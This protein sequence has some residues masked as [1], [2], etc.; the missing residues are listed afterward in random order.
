MSKKDED[1]GKQK[2][3]SVRTTA[4]GWLVFP[5][6]FVFL[7]QPPDWHF[8]QNY[9][10]N[11]LTSS[12]ADSACSPSTNIAFRPRLVSVGNNRSQ[13]LLTRVDSCVFTVFCGSV[14]TL[15]LVC[16]RCGYTTPSPEMDWET[17]KLWRQISNCSIPGSNFWN[18]FML[19]KNDGLRSKKGVFHEVLE[20]A[21]CC[22]STPAPHK[23]L[24][25]QTRARC[26][27]LFPHLLKVTYHWLLWVGTTV[28]PSW[29][30]MGSL[31]QTEVV[32][33]ISILNLCASDEK[34]TAA[35]FDKNMDK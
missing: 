22:A 8:H 14:D 20:S 26:G 21:A 9:Q 11:H 34:P 4:G 1:V 13:S 27:H 6:C 3:T 10:D 7:H 25:W 15:D 5:G 33:I 28:T 31:L 23:L 12:G 35:E 32:L 17:F 16:A 29:Q 24:W 18:S 2:Q 19:I 30:I